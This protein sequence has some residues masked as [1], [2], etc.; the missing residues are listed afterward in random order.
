MATLSDSAARVAA[1]L[2][3][4]VVGTH[5]L[6][7]HLMP[8]VHQ[9]LEE[10]GFP[11]IVERFCGDDGD[12]PVHK[13]L[14]VFVHSR[15]AS[16]KP[17]P[18]SCLEQWIADS[19]LPHLLET[20]SEK[21]NEYRIGRV[22][23]AVGSI[24]RGL[25]LELIEKAH[26]QYGFDLSWDI[27]DVSSI[28]FEGE[29]R[30]SDLAE[31]GYSRDGKPGTKQV[32]VGINVT[33]EDAIP[34]LYHLFPGNTEDSTTVVQNLQEMKAL[35]QRL[36][37]D[38]PPEVLGDRAMLSVPLVHRYLENK[39]DFIGSM[40]SCKVTDDLVASIPIELLRQSPLEYTAHRHRNLEGQKRE[41]ERYYGVRSIITIPA[42]KDVP[43]SKSVNLPCLVVLASGKCRLDAQHRETLISR[44]E[45]RVDEIS[46]H[47]NKGRYK[48]REYAQSQL[49][50][51]LSRYSAVSG[52]VSAEITG[53]DGALS[54][55][56]LRNEQAIVAAG[57]RDGKYVIIFN[58]RN[59]ATSEVFSRFK[60][61]DR[62]EKRI[63]DIKG[64]G[65]V[66]VRPVFLH[67][68]ERIRGLVLGCMVSLLVL[69]II[70]LRV[71]R[72]LQKRL[73]AEALQDVFR[74][75]A[76][77]LLT[78]SDDSQLVI[79]PTINK[80][81]QQILTAICVQPIEP[82]PSRAVYTNF[83]QGAGPSP[84]AW[85]SSPAPELSG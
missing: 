24:P 55:A 56:R 18:V 45:K 62:V 16:P 65:P 54:L 14:E 6:Q 76:A 23:E 53:S 46:G 31:Y 33:G 34:L 68:D 4:E 25:W 28:Y 42:H 69:S 48:S 17:V 79:M 9:V 29:Y 26:R 63:D 7:V 78:L 10:I 82:Q 32:N 64:A 84:P 22:L 3:K 27:Y 67:K 13:V 1:L 41:E 50:K 49:T 80:W 47:L 60:G 2:S 72:D 59:H 11:S 73:S 8:L 37:M 30:T 85:T 38:G 74:N 51:A 61:R 36:G 66:V 44:T 40:R 57:D 70:Q 15:V 81:Q 5:T 20:P 83:L 43:G 19:I 39:V 12:V 35:Y 71:K 21:F 77:S 52:F 75:H 58:N